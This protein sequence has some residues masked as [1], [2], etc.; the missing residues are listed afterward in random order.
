MKKKIFIIILSIVILLSS[1]CF[2]SA[3]TKEEIKVSELNSMADY[4]ILASTNQTRCVYGNETEE[5]KPIKS[6][7]KKSFIKILCFTCSVIFFLTSCNTT[8]KNDKKN[9][10]TEDFNIEEED[11]VI[12]FTMVGPMLYSGYTFALTPDNRVLAEYVEEFE[13]PKKF[14]TKL[15]DGQTAIMEEYIDE[16]LTLT[17]EDIEYTI[18]SGS[19]FWEC[20]V[21]YNDVTAHFTYGASESPAVNLLLELI[22]GYCASEKALEITEYA[23]SAPTRFRMIGK[24]LAQAETH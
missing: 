7:E 18:P 24:D 17:E 22:I 13:E 16:I 19:D 11:Y 5:I 1:I 10:N 9:L 2:V 4:V 21:S 20:S 8:I 12:Q 14:Q 15:S 6:Y 3:F 23:D